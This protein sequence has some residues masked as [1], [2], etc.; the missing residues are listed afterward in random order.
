MSQRESH[1]LWLKD[2]IE[3]LRD[4][5]EQLEWTE[6]PEMA[7]MLLDRL[8]RDLDCGRKICEIIKS[9]TPVTKRAA[10]IST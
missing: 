2:V 3:Q 1:I 10:P 7:R 8:M 6:D 5:R 4:C 9:R